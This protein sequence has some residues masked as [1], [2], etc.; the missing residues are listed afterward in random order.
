MLVFKRSPGNKGP[1]VLLWK[2]I[3]SNSNLGFQTPAPSLLLPW[4]ECVAQE[5]LT[6]PL[7]YPRA[8]PGFRAGLGAITPFCL[9]SRSAPHDRNQAWSGKPGQEPMAGELMA[10]AD[11]LLL[12]NASSHLLISVSV[13]CISAAL[14][15]REPHPAMMAINTESTVKVLR[16]SDSRPHSPKWDVHFTNPASQ[17]SGVTVEGRKTVGASGGGQLQG[18][19]IF[20]TH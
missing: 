10:R 9:D 6:M 2:L 4:E 18:S 8:Y 19:N 1:P 14:T 20:W 11:Q 5:P 16:I 7:L 17:S 15:L 3:L 12:L 13:Q